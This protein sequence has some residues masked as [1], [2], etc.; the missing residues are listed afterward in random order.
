[1]RRVVGG[2]RVMTRGGDAAMAETVDT[3]TT[4]TFLQAAAPRVQCLER[5]VL[6]AHV[7]WARPAAKSTYLLADTCAWLVKTM[8][9]SAVAVFLRI[10]LADRHGHRGAV[11]S[12]PDRLRPISSTGSPGSGSTRSP[13]YHQ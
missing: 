10:V 12:R 13:S 8:T 2:A 5:G 6:V 9:P 3:G 7:P 11:G 4:R 1:V